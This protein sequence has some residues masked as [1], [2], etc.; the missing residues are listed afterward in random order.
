VKV[1]ACDLCGQPAGEGGE[2]LGNVDVC[3]D[4]LS[5]PIRE[6]VTAY[7]A[8]AVRRREVR[9]RNAEQRAR[10]WARERAEW[11]ERQAEREAELRRLTEEVTP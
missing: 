9:D 4:C 3:A 2:R 5:R 10:A 11:A 1:S 7:R 6:L 8:D